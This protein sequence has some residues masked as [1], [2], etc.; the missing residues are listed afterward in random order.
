MSLPITGD[1]KK[2]KSHEMSPKYSQ[3][4]DHGEGLWN[5]NISLHINKQ[6]MSQPSEIF[7]LQMWMMAPKTAIQWMLPPSMLIAEELGERKKQPSATP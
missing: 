6:E 1:Q 2:K 5:E 3:I 7:G 4:Y